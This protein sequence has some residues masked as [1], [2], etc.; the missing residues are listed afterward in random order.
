MKHRTHILIAAIFSLISLQ[1]ASAQTA[2][3]ALTALQRLQNRCETGI[4]YVDYSEALAE[5]SFPFRQFQDA[6]EAAQNPEFNAHLRRAIEHYQFAGEIWTARFRAPRDD[7]MLSG[8]FIWHK[9]PLGKQIKERYPEA[10]TVNRFYPLDI[11]LPQIWNH[12]EAELTQA[13]AV[14]AQSRTTNPATPQAEN[15]GLPLESELQRLRRE[16]EELKNKLTEQ[17]AASQSA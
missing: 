15:N 13:E 5:A 8:G 1:W 7:R 4:A 12:A 3:D 10:E 11:I 14:L 6:E 17:E 16:N 2:T 9:G